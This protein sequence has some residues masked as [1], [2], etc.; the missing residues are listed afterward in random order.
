MYVGEGGGDEE[1]VH[2]SKGVTI[3]H[4]LIMIQSE[5]PHDAA[6]YGHDT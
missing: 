3:Q 1:E 5:Q 4:W 2:V 6:E